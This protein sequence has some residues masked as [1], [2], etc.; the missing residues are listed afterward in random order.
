MIVAVAPVHAVSGTDIDLFEGTQ[1]VEASDNSP[2]SILL[3]VSLSMMYYTSVLTP[4]SILLRSQKRTFLGLAT[5]LRTSTPTL[6]TGC[7]IP[8]QKSP[9]AC[10]ILVSQTLDESCTALFLGS[11]HHVWKAF[12][13]LR[14]MPS[15]ESPTA[16]SSCCRS[17]VRSF[18]PLARNQRPFLAAALAPQLTANAPVPMS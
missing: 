9:A 14:K 2:D 11:K 12:P 5:T 15:V 7:P 1:T 18:S 10:G 16:A 4:G 8:A 13:L 6:R 3:P 17:Y